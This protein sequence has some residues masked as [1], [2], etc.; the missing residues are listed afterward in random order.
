MGR[1]SQQFEELWRKSFE[2]SKLEPSPR[3]LRKLKFRLWTSDFLSINPRKFNILYTSLM[4]GGLISAF[5]YISKDNFTETGPASSMQKEVEPGYVVEQQTGPRPENLTSDL[6]VEDPGISNAPLASFEVN[7]LTGCAPY[8]IDF[9]NTSSAGEKYHWDFGTGEHSVNDNPSYTYEEAGNYEA[10][11]TVTNKQ[12]IQSTYKKNIEV[13]PS[14]KADFEID[15][16]N[17][18]IDKREI[19]FLNKSENATSY[20]WSFGDLKTSNAKNP[21]HNYPEYKTYNVKLI[22][23][24]EE[25]CTDETTIRNSFIGE[26][27]R[28]VF[29]TSFSP[30]PYGKSSDGYYDRARGDA[31]I[32]GPRHNSVKKF[33]MK[34]KATNGKVVFET[35]TIKQGWNGYWGGRLAPRGIYSYE[36]EGVYPNG[37]A[38]TQK[39][40]FKV[41]IEESLSY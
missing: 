3:V 14:P 19:K 35:N 40:K 13:L 7:S 34:I 32:F 8:T 28:L 6:T 20:T 26:D 25:G 31:S 9:K 30:Y 12:G 2:K 5:I 41:I 4:I 33:N 22:V 23:E 1:N 24:N 17:S 10:I 18:N 29:P 38:F 11:L 15:I 21:V 36:V 39:G 16:E 27:Y 37:K